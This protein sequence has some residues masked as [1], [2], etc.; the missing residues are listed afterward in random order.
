LLILD[1]CRDNPF[2]TASSRGI[3]GSR[4]LGRIDTQEGVFVLYSAGLGQAA[5]DRLN[6]KDADPNSVFTRTLIKLM[7]KPGLSM[8]ELAKTTQSE[9]KK[10]AATIGQF[11][12]PAYYDQIDGTLTLASATP[13]KPGPE[14]GQPFAAA[15]VLKHSN[16]CVEVNA[17]MANGAAAVQRDCSGK[18]NQKWEFSPIGDGYY[19][20]KARQTGKCMDVVGS[21]TQWGIFL[22]QWDCAGVDNQK[23]K[24]IPDGAGFYAITAKHSGLCLDILN[25]FQENVAVLLQWGCH[26]GDNQKFRLAM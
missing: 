21:G 20:I 23:F 13:A 26:G 8:Q 24:L 1:A 5:L 14:S 22:D 4:G 19:S 6:D 9:V 12:M 3:G 7:E 2:K 25:G 16:K 18:D 15:I 11:Q 10:L 17:Q